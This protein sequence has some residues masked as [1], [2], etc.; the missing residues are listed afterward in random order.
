MRWVRKV[1]VTFEMTNA[2]NF[3]TFLAKTMLS[4]R[5][6]ISNCCN[7]CWSY[8][9]FHDWPTH[10]LQIN[11]VKNSVVLMVYAVFNLLLKAYLD[12]FFNMIFMFYRVFLHPPFPFLTGRNLRFTLKGSMK[13]SGGGVLSYICHDPCLPV[14][15]VIKHFTLLQQFNHCLLLLNLLLCTGDIVL[16]LSAGVLKLLTE[17]FSM[18]SVCIW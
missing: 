9:L 16:Q 15:L 7:N 13:V 12:F 1:S 14:L 11:T 17:L 3:T 18:G 2:F 4:V 8:N 10:H 6:S 5:S